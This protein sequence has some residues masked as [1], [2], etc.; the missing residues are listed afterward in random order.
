MALERLSCS[1]A[2]CRGDLGGR[3]FRVLTR[4][5]GA[6]EL[7]ASVNACGFAGCAVQGV[8]VGARVSVDMAIGDALAARKD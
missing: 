3:P 4:G 6:L 2:E 7:L 1:R 8:A 5:P